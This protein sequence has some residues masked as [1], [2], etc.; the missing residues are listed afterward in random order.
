[1]SF[2]APSDWTNKTTS[3]IIKMCMHMQNRKHWVQ[4]YCAN[5][6]KNETLFRYMYVLVLFTDPPP[7]GW[8]E[9]KKKGGLHKLALQQVYRRID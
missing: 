5:W 4:A 3:Y 6:G 7:S 9:K 8:D 2:C 1:M